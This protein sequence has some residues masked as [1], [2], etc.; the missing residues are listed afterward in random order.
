VLHKL[1]ARDPKQ[2][3][4]ARWAR[5]HAFVVQSDSAASPKSQR[6]ARKQWVAPERRPPTFDDEALERLE[7]LYR[8]DASLVRY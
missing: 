4:S 3:C 5:K 1:L 7:A 2:R 8:T 6:R